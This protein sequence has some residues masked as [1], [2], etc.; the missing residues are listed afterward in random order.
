MILAT[1]GRFSPAELDAIDEIT[2]RLIRRYSAA[3]AQSVI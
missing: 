2:L 3:R 1:Q